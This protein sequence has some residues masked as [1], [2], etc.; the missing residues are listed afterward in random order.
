[1]SIYT[2]VTKE[3]LTNLD[4][5]AEQQ[6]NQRGIIKIKFRN[7]PIKK[8]AESLEPKTKRLEVI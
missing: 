1:M 5:L 2:N 3:D 6:K 7:E 4:E 8:L